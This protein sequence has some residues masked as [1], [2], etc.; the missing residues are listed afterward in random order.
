VW[1]YLFGTYYMPEGVLPQD[2]GIDDP[3]FPTSWI[4]QMVVPFKQFLSRLQ[5]AP[6][7]KTAG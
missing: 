1:D 4:G 3:L 7:N 6:K 5:D 2:Y